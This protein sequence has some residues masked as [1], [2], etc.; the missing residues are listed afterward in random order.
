MGCVQSRELGARTLPPGVYPA[1]RLQWRSTCWG[2]FCSPGGGGGGGVVG[3]WKIL[4]NLINVRGLLGV[5]VG[6]SF[7][8]CGGTDGLCPKLRAQCACASPSKVYP[9]GKLQ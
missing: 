6:S 8:R 2:W 9:A 1:G 3:G 7:Q 5:P 4:Q